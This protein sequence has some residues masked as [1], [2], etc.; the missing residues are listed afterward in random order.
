MH[1][2]MSELPPE[3][4]AR[5]GGLPALPAAN[6]SAM[7]L[8]DAERRR[9][10][11]RMEELWVARQEELAQAEDNLADLPKMLTARIQV[12]KEYLDDVPEGLRRVMEG[13]KGGEDAPAPS[14]EEEPSEMATDVIS[15]LRDLEYQLSDVDMARDF[16]TLGGWPY[17]VALL[18]DGGDGAQEEAEDEDMLLLADEV[19]ALAAMAMGTA[20]GNVAEFHGWALEAV[21]ANRTA[22]GGGP[23]SS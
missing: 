10:E 18:E 9:F 13:R 20:A 17:L 8:T 16:H 5:F 2:V 11:R 4:L 1:R 7:R 23:P 22:A 12:L 19:R 3:E 14:E 6:G 15:A 21:A